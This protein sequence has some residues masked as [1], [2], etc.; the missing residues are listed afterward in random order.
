MRLLL[1]FLMTIFSS[2]VCLAYVPPS[3]YII[4]ALSKKHA[5]FKGFR[6][7]TEVVAMEYNQPTEAKFKVIHTYN[8]EIQMLRSK[9]VND[10]GQ[11]LYILERPA[12]QFS[13][14][15]QLQ[16]QSDGNVLAKALREKDIPVLLEEESLKLDTEE[17]KRGAEK[18]HI[19]RI[20][21]TPVWVIGS[22][23]KDTPQLWIEKDTFLP[24]KAVFKQNGSWVEVQV[25][26][27]RYFR[28][29]PFPKSLSLYKD[30]SGPLLKEDVLEVQ[31]NPDVNEFKNNPTSGESGF[32][33]AGNI[34]PSSTRDL[35]RQYYETLR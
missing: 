2:S 1:V 23:D 19:A 6:I 34:L 5:G 25:E 4:N 13:I 9:A 21:N 30:G 7:R 20:K 12:R 28:E 35:I 32:T 17:K 14:L 27:Y 22:K 18:S 31:V 8:T 3:Q 11:V 33:D 24:L 10:A 15:N 26:A 29:F 16:F